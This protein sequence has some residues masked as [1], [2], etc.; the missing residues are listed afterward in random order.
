MKKMKQAPKA[1]KGGPIQGPSKAVP[2]G[3]SIENK[4][5]NSL[6]ADEV[7]EIRK[8]EKINEGIEYLGKI[9]RLW[10]DPQELAEMPPDF[11]WHDPLIIGKLVEEIK[12][13]C[14]HYGEKKTY[15]NSKNGMRELALNIALAIEGVHNF[16]TSFIHCCDEE[17]IQTVIQNG[18][19]FAY[20]CDLWVMFSLT[21]N[22]CNEISIL[23]DWVMCY[24]PEHATIFENRIWNPWNEHENLICQKLKDESPWETALTH[25][26]SLP[27]LVVFIQRFANVIGSVKDEKPW[28]RNQIKKHFG[29]LRKQFPDILT[30][31]SN[32]GPVLHKMLIGPEPENGWTVNN[33]AESLKPIEPP[34]PKEPPEKPEDTKEE[35]RASSG[36]SRKAVAKAFGILEDVHLVEHVGECWQLGAEAYQR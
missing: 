12:K 1:K 11:V 13:G 18:S 32:C 25:A 29:M 5:G 9:M 10:S 21:P 34:K 22:T 7:G 4:T 31:S 3:E 16:M 27:S 2:S 17:S 15:E 19:P 30:G 33:M 36:G 24:M 35:K 26:Y 20:N 14:K 6:A 23:R 8:A 28:E